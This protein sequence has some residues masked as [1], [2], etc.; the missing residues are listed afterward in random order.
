M[1]KELGI[2]NVAPDNPAMAVR[3]KSS[4]VVKSNP[5]FFIWTVMIPHIGQMA[6]PHNR[7]GMEIQ[8]FRFAIFLP[9]EFQNCS[10]ST[11]HSVRSVFDMS[12]SSCYMADSALLGSPQSSI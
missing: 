10:S 9:V 2:R 12:L 3:E 7:L 11:F 5:R 4:A 6:N 8:R 1:K